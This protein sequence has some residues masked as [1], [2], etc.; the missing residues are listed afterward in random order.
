MLSLAVVLSIFVAVALGYKLKI[1][2][3]L[4]GIAFSY[5][6]GCVIM[7]M[8][9]GKVIGMWPLGLFF[10]IMMSSFFYGIAVTNGT[11]ALFSEHMI[12]RFRRHPWFVPVMMWLAC[13]IV[14]GLG[15]GPTTVFAFMPAIVLSMA[16]RINM[17][18]LVAAVIIVGGGVAG[19]YSPISLCYQVVNNCLNAAGFA[20]GAAPDMNRISFNVIFAQVLIFIVIYLL[21]K[22]WKARLPEDLA[23]PA[24]FTDQQ[25][26]T[27]WLIGFGMFIMVLFPFLKVLMPEVALFKKISAALDPSLVFTVLLVISLMLKL[28]DQ[29]KAMNFIPW[30]T[31]LLICGTGM[32]VS[33]TKATGAID[34]LSKWLGN[35]MT[36]FMTKLVVSLVAGGMSFFSST[37]GVVA[38]TL[39]PL[40]PGISQVTGVTAV[41]LLSAI[42]FGGHVAGVSPFSVGGAMVLAGE[43]VEEK[44]N[45]LFIQLMALSVGSML[46]ASLLNI[47]GVF[48]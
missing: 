26:K 3:G 2:V 15:P 4:F 45:L 28:G 12:Y 13:F 31:I 10:F 20:A 9:T 42:M 5:I 23:K 16:E 1:N 48:G 19:G 11:L 47:L 39:F 35:N 32:L 17:N 36:P 8:K 30:G 43:T 25:K 41:S 22:T 14:S 44:K 7:G 18:K 24:A 37:L 38:P 33:V 34:Y 21:C 6:F 40:I 46:F 29:K 27:L